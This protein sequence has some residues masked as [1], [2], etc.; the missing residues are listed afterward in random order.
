MAHDP[1]SV[2]RA[3][4]KTRKTFYTIARQNEECDSMYIACVAQNKT[5][6]NDTKSPCYEMRMLMVGYQKEM[7]RLHSE[8]CELAGNDLV[9]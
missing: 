9:L 2:E 4:H 6:W 1:D 3:M 5:R 7:T 8:Y